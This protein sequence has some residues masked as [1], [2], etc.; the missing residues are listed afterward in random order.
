[1]KKVDAPFRRADLA[2]AMALRSVQSGS[3]QQMLRH[4]LCGAVFSRGR[5][6]EEGMHRSI[7]SFAA[8]VLSAGWL[9]SVQPATAQGQAEP[10]SISD[11]KL[12]QTAAAMKN[13]MRIRDDYAQKLSAASPDEQKEIAGE[14]NAALKKAV[15][16]QGLSVEEYASIVKVAQNDPA[17]RERLAQRLGLT[18][19]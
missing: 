18:T 15:T 8:A 11:Q 12:D 6:V 3:K 10:A 14:A 4:L 9:L 2:D 16:D 7:V 13:V 5:A 1:M 17:V 19:K